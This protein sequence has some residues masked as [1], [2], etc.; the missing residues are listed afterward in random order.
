MNNVSHDEERYDFIVVGAG[1]AG[2]VLAAEL[3]ASGAQYSWSNPGAR[4]MRR[5]S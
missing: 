3:S 4:T 5:R 1:S 2:S